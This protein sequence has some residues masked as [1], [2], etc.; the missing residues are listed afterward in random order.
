MARTTVLIVTGKACRPTLER[1]LSGNPRWLAAEVDPEGRNGARPSILA[2]HA[3]GGESA[4]FDLGQVDPEMGAAFGSLPCPLAAF[5]A[6]PLVRGLL[7]HGFSLPPRIACVKI[8]E[9]LIQ[10]SV[11]GGSSELGPLAQRYGM[12]PIPD[13][14]EG[15][16]ALLRVPEL[17]SSVLERQISALRDKQLVWVSR[18]ESAVL[19]AIAEMEHVGVPLDAPRWRALLEDGRLEREAL[20]EELAGLLGGAKDLFGEHS[21]LDSEPGLREALRRAGHA[22]P[23][24]RRDTLSA[25]PAPLGPKLGRFRELAKLV[26][27]YGATF[28]DKVDSAGRIHATFEQIGASTGRMA[29]HSPNLQSVVKDSPYRECFRATEGR[30]LVTADYAGCELR[31]IAELSGD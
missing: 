3:P 18:I 5:D 14:R 15:I 25:L 12:G 31:I 13:A 17:V 16:D 20:R 23:N 9:I 11:G 21:A 7:N 2:L 30:A 27:A 6:K 10:G 29:C 28:L 4:A 26:Q 24:M 1:L 19:P 22:V 8:I